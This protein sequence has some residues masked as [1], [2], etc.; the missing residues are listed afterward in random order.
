MRISRTWPIGN[1]LGQLVTSSLPTPLTSP[2]NGYQA[3]Q[4]A[5][6]PQQNNTASMNIAKQIIHQKKKEDWRNEW[7]NSVTVRSIFNHMTTPY[8]KDPIINSLKREEQVTIF[9]LRSQHAPLNSHLKRIGVVTDSRCS[10]CPCP[11]E[12]VAHHLFECPTLNDLRTEF[13]PTKADIANTL[14][15]NPDELRKTHRYFVMANSRRTRAQWL[16]DQLNK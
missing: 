8:P 13:L 2:Y 7:A 1:W 12:T 6:W 5:R 16:L 4:G 15:A 9:R 11:D 3:K 14:Y 10:L